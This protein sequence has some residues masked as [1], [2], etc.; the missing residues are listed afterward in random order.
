MP[1]KYI[2][3]PWTAPKEIQKAA[4]C[5]IGK[6]YPDHLVD[7]VERREICIQRLKVIC[8]QI[9]KGTGWSICRWTV[10]SIG[11][12]QRPRKTVPLEAVYNI[13]GCY[14]GCDIVVHL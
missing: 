3:E 12:F 4:N 10:T 14:P 11:P 5:I 1:T 9:H 6:D 2:Y 13:Q 7:H 8:R